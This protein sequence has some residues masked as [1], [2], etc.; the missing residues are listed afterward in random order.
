MFA[1]FTL[2]CIITVADTLLLACLQDAL[3][4]VRILKVTLC[5]L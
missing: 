5:S 1:T 3:I 2:A 4:L